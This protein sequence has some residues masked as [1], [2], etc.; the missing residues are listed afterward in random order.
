M[1]R[2]KRQPL[3]VKLTSLILKKNRSVFEKYILQ[4]QTNE[5]LGNQKA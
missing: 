4:F 1:A 2:F 3:K 5:K